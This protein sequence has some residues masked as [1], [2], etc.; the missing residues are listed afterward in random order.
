M[1]GWGRIVGYVEWYSFVTENAFDSDN[2]NQNTRHKLLLISQ[3]FSGLLD[4][5]AGLLKSGISTGSNNASR[6]V[7]YRQAM[8]MMQVMSFHWIRAYTQDTRV[9]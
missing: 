7:G 3:V 6:A 8:A 5:A 9:E 1:G 4:E 2:F